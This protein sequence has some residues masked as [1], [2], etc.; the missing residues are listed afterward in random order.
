MGADA[1]ATAQR[2]DRGYIKLEL[3]DPHLD[4]TYQL[5]VILNDQDQHPLSFAIG[6]QSPR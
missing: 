6:L 2:C 4:Q 3:V 1:Q 5:N